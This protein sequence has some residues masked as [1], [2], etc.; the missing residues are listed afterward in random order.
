MISRIISHSTHHYIT[1]SYL[2]WGLFACWFFHRKPLTA[3]HTVLW[4]LAHSTLTASTVLTHLSYPELVFEMGLVRHFWVSMKHLMVV[5]LWHILHM[6]CR[7]YF[8]QWLAYWI[9]SRIILILLRVILIVS[10]FLYFSLLEYRPRR[11]IVAHV[12]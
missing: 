2:F 10:L 3:R 1:W 4:E 8:L 5:V 12:I 11:F 9:S 6:R 7:L